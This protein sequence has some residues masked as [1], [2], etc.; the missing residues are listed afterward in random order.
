M[1]AGVKFTEIKS[2]L[3][4]NKEKP[5]DWNDYNSIISM[6]EYKP[7][8]FCA[9]TEAE[10]KMY[11][12]FDKLTKKS[13]EKVF[14]Q[15]D[16][17][18]WYIKKGNKVFGPYTNKELIFRTQ[19]GELHGA[20]LKRE[21]DEVFLQSEIILKNLYDEKKLDEAFSSVKSR[22]SEKVLPLSARVLKCVKTS[23]FLITK[24]SQLGVADVLRLVKGKTKQ[25]ALNSL[26]KFSG[27]E[28]KDNITVL[29]LFLE[30]IGSEILK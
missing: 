16:V 5:E 4:T 7:I 18:K 27:L 30:E 23:K 26:N 3:K 12:T 24:R 29:K 14:A 13:T 20:F 17:S 19:N 22:K 15:K 28:K 21:Q 11:T 9:Y 25:D 2:F 8:I 10:K 6:E 1:S